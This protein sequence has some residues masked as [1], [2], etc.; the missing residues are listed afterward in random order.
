MIQQASPPLAAVQFSFD[1]RRRR[2]FH[3]EHRDQLNRDGQTTQIRHI[4][5][6]ESQTHRHSLLRICLIF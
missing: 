5:R 1:S 6:G 2:Q 3:R 4:P